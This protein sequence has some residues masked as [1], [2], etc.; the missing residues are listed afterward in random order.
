MFTFDRFLQLGILVTISLSGLLLG[1]AQQDMTIAVVAILGAVTAYFVT[2][3]FKWFEF[4]QWFANA[5][6]ILVTIYALSGFGGGD[7]VYQLK[8]V[9]N[10]LV[11]LQTILLFQKKTPRLHWQVLVLSLLQVVVAAVF[12][13]GF[14]GGLLFVA[15]MVVAGCT[16]M[17][18]HL[19]HDSWNVRSRN[20]ELRE[21]LD[22]RAKTEQEQK[23]IWFDPHP[24]AIYEHENRDRSVLKRQFRHYS[25]LGFA[26]IVFTALMFSMVPRDVSSWS[27]PDDQDAQKVGA[28]KTINLDYTGVIEL[29][30]D[31]I[32]RVSY[33]DVS[34]DESVELAEPPY[35]RGMPLSILTYSKGST[36]WRAPYERVSEA[37]FEYPVD[38]FHY[39][40]VDEVQFLTQTVVLEPTTDPLLYSADPHLRDRTTPSQVKYCREL[41]CLSREVTK[42]PNATFE[43]SLVVARPQSEPTLPNFVPAG[44]YSVE[45]RQLLSQGSMAFSE[46]LDMDYTRYPTLARKAEQLSGRLLIRDVSDYQIA[47]NLEKHFLDSNI[48]RYTLD[49]SSFPRD[50]ALDPVE[51]FVKNH[52]SGHCEYFASALTLMLRSQ[53][54]PARLVVGYRGGEFNNIGKYYRVQQ[55]HAHAWVEAYIKPSDVP[56]NIAATSR[57]AR[58]FGIWLRLDPTPPS[59]FGSGGLI[60]NA[61]DALDLARAFWN[62]YVV[63]MSGEGELT[64]LAGE[65]RSSSVVAEL[66]R[67][68]T[69]GRYM[70]QVRDSVTNPNSPFF[71][72]AI[73]GTLALV[74]RFIHQLKKRQTE[75]LGRK[76]RE[77]GSFRQFIGKLVRVVSPRL[78]DW[79]GGIA[80]VTQAEVPFYKDLCALLARYDF[81]REPSITQ[82]EFANQIS[83]NLTDSQHKLQATNLLERLTSL[84]YQV[85]FGGKTLEPQELAFA[86]SAL[87]ELEDFFEKKNQPN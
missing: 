77:V 68:D 5:A 55:K 84:F 22:A 49:L 83:R 14:E 78:G 26:A 29:S 27:G 63:R 33:Y 59:N 87:E 23:T 71:Y 3:Y 16:T 79:I 58:R 50:P 19:H 43:Y 65:R 61:S 48:Y 11:Y 9:A 17:L 82:L 66:M 10:L 31:L 54:I 72:F 62:D 52:R 38:Q 15:Y 51:D 34:R 40:G 60:T 41:K 37:S 73:L 56:A 18:L 39:S 6:A 20:E 44:I 47:L 46:L 35:L 75:L 8:V 30:S 57:S 32:M 81:R 45:A 76:A 4:D 69:W 64:L 1:F 28:S 42:M 21:K 25:G 12:N 86:K 80:P 53:R 13:L 85:R 67:L 7:R 70:R 24:V 74:A 2:E 36:N